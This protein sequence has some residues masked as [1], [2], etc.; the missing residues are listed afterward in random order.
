[1]T[2][3]N[4]PPVGF[5]PLPLPKQGE[6]G[7]ASMCHIRRF[8]TLV[9]IRSPCRSK[10]RSARPCGS[11]F[12]PS[13][14]QGEIEQCA[15]ICDV[16]I[17][18]PCRSKGR[19]SPAPRYPRVE[20][21]CFNPLPLP[22]QGE[23]AARFRVAHHVAEV[24]GFNPL[25]LPKQGEIAVA[26]S[27]RTGFNP[28]PLPKQGE[29]LPHSFG[30]T[31]DP[32]C[33]NPLPLPKQGEIGPRGRAEALAKTFQSAPP[34]EARG[35][36]SSINPQ[37]RCFNPLPLPKQGEMSGSER[38]LCPGSWLFQSAPPAEARGDDRVPELNTTS[39]R[40]NP[41]PLPKQGEMFDGPLNGARASA[42]FN[43]LPLPKQGEI[44][45]GFTARWTHP[46]FPGS[47][48]IRS[49]CRSKGRLFSR[50][51]RRR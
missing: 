39:F 31:A 23:M 47:V 29:I 35:D 2:V 6:I 8:M 25:P 46:Q 34:A 51:G 37:R 41:L 44:R 12:N 33:F 32:S 4:G 18:S 27:L 10:G 17:R 43:P 7:G 5:N 50:G 38:R 21:M 19:L 45:I 26:R 15:T 14:S 24:C 28:L 30:C 42:S 1:M 13:P 11:R 16:S 22:K 36:R 49:P 20:Q 3:C 48:S 40:F 9:S